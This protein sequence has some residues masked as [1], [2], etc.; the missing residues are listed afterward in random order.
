MK[1]KVPDSALLISIV[2]S[3]AILPVIT[4]YAFMF[5]FAFLLFLIFIYAILNT[6]ILKGHY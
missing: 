1:P 3:Q 6:F 5:L 2:N 4:F